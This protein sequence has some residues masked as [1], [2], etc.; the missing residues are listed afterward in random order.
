MSKSETIHI[1]FPNG[2][3]LPA[4]VAGGKERKVGPHE[5]VKVP[6]AYGT[7]LIDDRFAYEADPAK[8][9]AQRTA[10]HA[11]DEREAAV[12]KAETDVAAR[13]EAVKI[14]EAALADG[15]SSLFGQQDADKKIG[16][17]GDKA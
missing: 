15:D 11:A 5:A 7:S 9:K 8:A 14:A 6:R 10:R 3:T 4:D 16:G 2:G 1:A 12:T 13:E 17:K